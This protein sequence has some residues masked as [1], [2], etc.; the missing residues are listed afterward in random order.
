MICACGKKRVKP[1]NLVDGICRTCRRAGITPEGPL[2]GLSPEDVNEA[3][4]ETHAALNAQLEG[5]LPE[6]NELLPLEDFSAL[7][8]K[9]QEKYMRKKEVP[10]V[11]GGD[12][13]DAYR[14][15]LAANLSAVSGPEP[16]G[17]SSGEPSEASG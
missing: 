4:V 11:P 9:S 6:E 3:L 2:E 13:I 10:W 12:R 15:F 17:L 5:A 8:H 1:K 14:T 7:H 16:G